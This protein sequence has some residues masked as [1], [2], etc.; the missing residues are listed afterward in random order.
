MKAKTASAF[1][2]HLM[3]VFSICLV[4]VAIYSNS[5]HSHFA[6]D[7]LTNISSNPYIRINDINL[8]DLYDAGFKSVLPKRPVSYISFALNYYF[9]QFN[10]TGYHVFNIVVHLINGILVYLLA[11][12]IFKQ[13]YD[14]QRDQSKP[15]HIVSIQLPSL[16]AA[17]VFIT[18]P[19]QTQS[20]TYITQRMNSMAVM[21]YL[22]ALFLYI[23][24]RRV[25]TRNM[26][27]LFFFGCFVSWIMA[28][29][30]KEIAA[31]LPIIVLLFEWYFFQD[32]R[33]EWLMKNLRYFLCVFILIG[34]LVLYFLG[35]TPFDEILTRYSIRDFT[36]EQRVLT[37]P[38]VVVFYMSLLLYPHPSRLNLLHDISTSTSLLVPITTILSLLIII[39]L[40][41]LAIYLGKNHRLISFCILW[42]F[43]NLA[44][45]SSVIGLMM[46]FEHRLYLPMFG[47]SLIVFHLLFNKI[48]KRTWIAVS[49][50]LIIV[51]FLGAGTY[52]RN[53]VWQDS[54]SLWTSVVSHND[55]SHIGHNN[56]GLELARQG[57]INEAIG[58]YDKALKL[59][60]NY[61]KA[62]NNIGISLSNI[63]DVSG[64]IDHYKE[65][66]RIN[67]DCVSAHNNW[68]IALALQG[69]L[70]EA[71]GHYLDALSI[72]HD[73]AAAHYN[74][75]RALLAR[76]QPGPQ[77][78]QWWRVPK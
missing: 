22:C 60:P 42:F 66:L 69:R 15:F 58:H 55:R 31:T 64:A 11:L 4:C 29:G 6:Y 77:L 52:L 38:R 54:E 65:A 48:L 8:G 76:N 20:V 73:F 13:A 70:D 63:G 26:R 72:R 67:P 44:I 37:Q 19:I 78:G 2:Y 30:S 1:K 56:L 57:R 23:K 17:L 14:I 59:K 71:I 47:V 36:P 10:V 24:G 74:L 46:I 45:E 27:G 61:A 39:G 41:G 68:G 32:F 5:L 33:R 12:I 51:L 75:K 34:L 50:S 53:E 7:D 43:I 40:I 21:F 3:A 16:F 28:L 25:Q 49:I 62:H 18:H 9:G 35:A